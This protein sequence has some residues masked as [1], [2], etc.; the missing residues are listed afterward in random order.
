MLAVGILLTGFGITGGYHRLVTHRS[1]ALSPVANSM[2]IALGSMALQVSVF[3]WAATHRQHHQFSDRT[4]ILILRVGQRPRS[5][6]SSEDS[7]TPTRAGS[8]IQGFTILAV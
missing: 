6:A 1:Y 5:A 8:L 7:F 2:V 3:D 4:A